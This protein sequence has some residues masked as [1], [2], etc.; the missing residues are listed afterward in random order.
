MCTYHKEM[1]GLT[2][3]LSCECERIS[4]EDLEDALAVI[5]YIEK[6]DCRTYELFITSDIV[7]Q[8]EETHS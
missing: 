1:T 7:P 6:L 2:H 5:D 8:R 3:K 4:P